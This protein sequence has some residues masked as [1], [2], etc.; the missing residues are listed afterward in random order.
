MK[1]SKLARMVSFLRTHVSDLITNFVGTWTFVTIY[2]ILILVWIYF[3]K[4]N[5][6][7]Y[8]AELTYLNFFLCWLSG[9]QASIVMMSD[10]RRED[11]H[12]ADQKK[13]LELSEKSLN[14]D[15]ANKELIKK[16]TVKVTSMVDK[17][18]KLENLIE[19]MEQEEQEKING[20][21]KIKK[22]KFRRED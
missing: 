14:A 6:I 12:F 20:S 22:P 11:K 3:H 18:N 7:N 1:K 8:D 10:G 9:I 5:L 4:I 2:T 17:I 21:G 15:L 19:L 13:E 16:M